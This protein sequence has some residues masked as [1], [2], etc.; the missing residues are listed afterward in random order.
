LI[1]EARSFYERLLRQS[2]AALAD[3]NLPRAEVA[4][5]LAALP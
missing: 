3:G 5:G 4:A 1:S 2:D